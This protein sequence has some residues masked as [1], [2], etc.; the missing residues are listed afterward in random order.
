MCKVEVAIIL[1]RSYAGYAGYESVAH[2]T[3]VHQEDKKYNTISTCTINYQS[4]IV[5]IS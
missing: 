3:V 5:A 1:R 4:E 2:I